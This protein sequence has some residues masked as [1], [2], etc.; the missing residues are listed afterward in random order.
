MEVGGVERDAVEVGA[1]ERDAVEVGAGVDR[2]SIV[3][4]SLE[5]FHTW[6]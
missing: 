3:E 1:V 6:R 4:S 2:A 5:E